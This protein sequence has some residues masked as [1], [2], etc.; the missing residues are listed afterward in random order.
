MPTVFGE[1]QGH[2]ALPLPVPAF[3]GVFA[4]KDSS[5][6]E[7]GDFCKLMLSFCFV[8]DSAYDP[9]DDQAE[10]TEPGFPSPSKLPEPETSNQL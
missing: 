8:G 10:S 4:T 6:A 1:G 5:S 9:D 2:L 7:N 3:S